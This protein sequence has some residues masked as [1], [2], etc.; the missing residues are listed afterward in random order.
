MVASSQLVHK[1]QFSWVSYKTRQV[2]PNGIELLKKRIIGYDWADL[3]GWQSCPSMVTASM[4]G[5]FTEA[6]DEYIP[7]KERR[8]RSTDDVSMFII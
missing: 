3:P 4:H 8:V 2:T 6:M 7:F 1:H 5:I